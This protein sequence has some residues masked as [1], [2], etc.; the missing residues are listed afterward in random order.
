MYTPIRT[1]IALFCSFALALP[2]ACGDNDS[3]HIPEDPGVNGTNLPSGGSASNPAG[4]Y[5][6]HFL[7]EGWEV[8]PELA[9]YFSVCDTHMVYIDGDLNL[10]VG[11]QSAPL[12]DP[13]TI[14]LHKDG[15]TYTGQRVL[16]EDDGAQVTVTVELRYNDVAER[17]ESALQQDLD[18]DADGTPEAT[19][20]ATF[21]LE[22]RLDWT[23]LREAANGSFDGLIVVSRPTD[24]ATAP[25]YV[26]VGGGTEQVRERFQVDAEG[27]LQG[28]G[29]KAWF[30]E[31][32]AGPTARVTDYDSGQCHEV[33]LAP[34]AGDY[35]EMTVR[36]FVPPE[37]VT[38]PDY[39]TWSL[40]ET[41]HYTLYGGGMDLPS[42]Q[43]DNVTVTAKPGS[44]VD[45]D[46]NGS[47]PGGGP[48][49]YFGDDLASGLT[50]QISLRPMATG[51]A[52]ITPPAETGEAP[53]EVSYGYL[54]VGGQGYVV[55]TRS[56]VFGSGDDRSVNF[57]TFVF[58]VDSQ[59]A[60]TGDG[61]IQGYDFPLRDGSTA[62]SLDEW[63][64][65]DNDGL[66]M[67]GNGIDP[68]LLDFVTT[69]AE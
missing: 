27:A 10:V 61:L 34:L 41:T 29:P 8:D 1:I 31:G 57:E 9:G 37:T 66:L 36:T 12:A 6:G 3:G 68:T 49:Y 22:P 40:T 67:F 28:Q 5:V 46:T 54:R 42:F 39:E 65:M 69:P 44:Q 23:D 38:D 62:I 43:Q 56:V 16:T 14:P 64:A 45:R 11:D 25:D 53:F 33:V 24:S 35:G 20:Q 21:R 60:L 32:S 51:T 13:V 58:A 63:T 52:T 26:L 59:G 50:A 30:Y 4:K 17:W 7:T 55:M 47:D 15:G 18:S 2:C 19:G 48:Y